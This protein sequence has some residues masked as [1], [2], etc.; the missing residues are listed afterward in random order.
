MYRS[1]NNTVILFYLMHPDD[2]HHNHRGVLLDVE[3]SP[4][5]IDTG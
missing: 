2:I 4:L 3:F 1:E 5:H